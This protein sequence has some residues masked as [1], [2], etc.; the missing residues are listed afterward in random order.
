MLCL[1][2]LHLRIE[3]LI[4]LMFSWLQHLLYGDPS[5]TSSDNGGVSPEL[6]FFFTD[7]LHDENFELN[8]DAFS[9][10]SKLLTQHKEAASEFLKEN[11]GEVSI[12]STSSYRPVL[13]NAQWYALRLPAL[14]SHFLLRLQFFRLYR[15]LLTSKQYVTRRQSLKVGAAVS[16]FLWLL[17]RSPP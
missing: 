7:V 9:T 11:Y 8:L 2:T 15:L 6:Q 3:N 10:L 4:L 5:S 12:H 17:G 16:L 1:L 14:L 13:C